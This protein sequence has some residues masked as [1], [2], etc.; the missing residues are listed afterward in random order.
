MM[1]SV[2]KILTIA[3]M[4]TNSLPVFAEGTG[5]GIPKSKCDKEL[6]K[7]I[8][9][10]GKSDLMDAHRKYFVEKETRDWTPGQFCAWLKLRH[11]G[12]TEAEFGCTQCGPADPQTGVE[13]S[14]DGPFR[15]QIRDTANRRPPREVVEEG[16]ERVERGGG[17]GFMGSPFM[18]GLLGGALG[19]FL[20]T[21]LASRMGQQQQQPYFPQ[22]FGQYGPQ[23]PPGMMPIPR[24][25]GMLPMPGQFG[26]Q[27]GGGAVAPW[28]APYLGGQQQFAGIGGY[29]AGAYGQYGGGGYGGGYAAPGIAPG[30][31]P[32]VLP[33]AP[34]SNYGVGG[35]IPQNHWNLINV[36]R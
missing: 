34:Q 32:G 29:G 15:R 11:Q 36:G 25:P 5:S 27:M 26:G 18:G 3:S 28:A 35:S 2:T 17:G 8:Y 6:V 7:E 12:K 31:A 22:P 9:T 1:K 33:L 10:E 16:E 23:G 14:F 19:G 30:L 20:G 13:K 24:A 4:L 21:F